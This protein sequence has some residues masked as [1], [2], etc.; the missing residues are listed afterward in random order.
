MNL[1]YNVFKH[2]TF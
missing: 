2:I 1:N